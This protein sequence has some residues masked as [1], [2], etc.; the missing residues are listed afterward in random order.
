LVLT[1]SPPS[2]GGKVAVIVTGPPAV[3]PITTKEADNCPGG[4]VK[5]AGTETMELFDDVI[6]TVVLVLCAELMVSVI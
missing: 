6:A 3:I 1:V 2:A 5:D 4:I